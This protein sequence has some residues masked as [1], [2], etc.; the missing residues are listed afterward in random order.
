MIVDEIVPGFLAACPGLA[1]PWQ[2]HLVLCGGDDERGIYVDVSVIAQ[3]LVDRFETQDVS[4]FPATFALLERCLA[5]GDSETR[6]VAAIGII[7]AIQ[8]I[9][10]HRPFGPEAFEPWLLDKTRLAWIQVAAWWRSEWVLADQMEEMLN[11]DTPV[12]VIPTFRAAL[13]FA[14]ASVRVRLSRRA[15]CR[16]PQRRRRASAGVVVPLVCPQFPGPPVPAQYGAAPAEV[17]AYHAPASPTTFRDDGALPATAR[18]P[19]LC[20]TLR[21]P[22]RRASPDPWSLAD[23]Q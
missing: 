16:L 10:S 12:K 2:E 21:L 19:M 5:E 1:S 3:H 15:S 17:N 7:E 23:A 22:D 20:D 14:P 8:N 4:E 11:A 13:P 6:E 9:A 18:F